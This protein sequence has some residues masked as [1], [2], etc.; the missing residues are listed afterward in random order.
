MILGGDEFQRTQKGNNNTYC[1][2]NDLSWINWD[3]LNSS[4]DIFEFTKK[5]I[6]VRKKYPVLR[7]K[8]FLTGEDRDKDGVPDISWFDTDW[9]NPEKK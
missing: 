4:K 3:L 7:T 9:D 1:Q 5:L 8:R 2:D 6:A